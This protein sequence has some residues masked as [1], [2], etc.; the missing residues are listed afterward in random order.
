M[1]TL[2]LTTRRTEEQVEIR[3]QD[4]GSGMPLDIIEQ[5]FNPFFTTKPTGQ[6]TGLGLSICSDI[7]R[8][9]GGTIEVVS[10]PE[11]YTE[12]VIGLPLEAPELPDLHLDDVGSETAA[13]PVGGVS[14]NGEDD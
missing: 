8:E 4:N 10:E 11:Q 7:I 14:R 2:L 1:P 9:H 3:I 12:M 13:E 5:I 6:G